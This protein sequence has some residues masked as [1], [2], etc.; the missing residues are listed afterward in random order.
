MAGS[1]IAVNVRDAAAIDQFLRGLSPQQKN[2]VVAKS[3][4]E[5]A[6]RTERKARDEYIVKGRGRNAPP[7][8]DKLTSRTYRLANS[9]DTDE[10]QIPK[11]ARVGTP[12][13]YA[14][15][16]EQGLR[17]RMVSSRGKTFQQ[18]FPR[19]PFLEP[20]AREV[21]RKEASGVFIR[22]IRR[23]RAKA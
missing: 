14:P 18:T 12:V 6:R 7:L 5:I 22:E 4:R 20:A 8:R 23:E 21:I 13:K 1:R 9:I 11:R 16:H 19:R 10:R 3:L 15:V 17:V 2:R